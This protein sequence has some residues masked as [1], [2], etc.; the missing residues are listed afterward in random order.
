MHCCLI[1]YGRNKFVTFKHASCHYENVFLN[2]CKTACLLVYVLEFFKTY[3]KYN[4]NFLFF[5]LK[6]TIHET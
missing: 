6:R 1:I 3:V 2:K 4:G 5:F